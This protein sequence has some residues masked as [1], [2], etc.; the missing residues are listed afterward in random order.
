MN[1]ERGFSVPMEKRDVWAPATPE[2]PV[3]RPNQTPS[4]MQ[5]NQIGVENWQDLLGFYTDVLQDELPPGWQPNSRVDVN[6]GE[7][8]IENFAGVGVNQREQTIQNVAPVAVLNKGLHNV[9]GVASAETCNR[10]LPYSSGSAGVVEMSH[11][12]GGIQD[13]AP[14]DKFRSF[15]LNAGNAGSYLQN[16]DDV[17]PPLKVSSLAELLGMRSRLNAPTTNGD[18]IISAVEKHSSI[19]QHSQVERNWEDSIPQQNHILHANPDIGGYNLQ[20]MPSSRLS[21]AY[22]PSYN[23]NSPQRSEAGE[24][25]GVAGPLHLGTVTPDQQKEL[26]NNQ[27][28]QIP[29]LLID[30]ISTKEGHN[31]QN[32]MLPQ[33]AEIG[34][35]KHCDFVSDTLSTA[36]PGISTKEKHNFVDGNGEFD[37]NKTPPQKTPKRKKHRPKVVKEGKPRRTPKPAAKENKNPSGNPATKRKYVRKKGIKTSTNESV[38]AENGVEVPNSESQGKSCKRALNFDLENGI[39]KKT[40]CKEFDHQADNNQGGNASINLNVDFHNAGLKRNATCAVKDVHQNICREQKQTENAYNFILS[41][42]KI[43]S[44]ESLT[45]A[46]TV[47]PTASKDHTLNVIARNLNVRST[48]INQSGV[49]GKYGQVHHQT[50]GGL[51]QLVIL[52]NTS[53]QNLDGLRQSS[54]QSSPQLLEDLVNIREKQKPKRVYFHTEMTQPLMISQICSRGVSET[55]HFNKESTRPWLNAAVSSRSNTKNAETK[56]NG[57]GAGSTSADFTEQTVSPG[58]KRL[59]AQTYKLHMNG[60]LPCF[61]REEMSTLMNPAYETNK[62]THN[63][64]MNSTGSGLQFQ[65]QMAD[66]KYHPFAEAQTNSSFTTVAN[67]HLLSISNRDPKDIKRNEITDAPAHSSAKRQYTRRTPSN[68]T[69]STDKVLQYGHD[70]KN[71]SGSQE[72]KRNIFSVDDIT[73][74]MR[75]LQIS[76]NGNRTFEEV[77]NALVPYTGGGAVVPYEPSDP[78]KKRRPR[79]KVDLDPETNRLWNLLM[80]N[81][82]SESTETMDEDKQKRWEED[83]RVFRGRVDSFTARMHLV[84]GDRKFSKWKGSVVDSV[85]GVF[86]TQNVSDHL[87]S[88]AF[89]SLAAKFS[90]KSTNSRETSCQKAGN[91]SAEYVVL[92]RHP[93]GTTC[94]Q[95]MTREPVYDQNTVKSSKL[96]EYD[97]ENVP[98]GT[99]SVN[100]HI[101]RTEEGMVSSQMT[102]E[103]VYDHNTV[104]SSKLSEYDAENVPS[105]T[106][107]VN[108]H[109]RR[110]DE[111]MV[112]SQS[113]SESINFHPSEDIRS[114]SGSNSEVE[115]QVTGSNSRENCGPLYLF[116]E[117]EGITA[118]QK[119]QIPEIGFSF[120]DNRFSNNHHQYA[121]LGNRQYSGATSSTNACTYPLPSNVLHYQR[122]APASKSSW[123]GMGN[124]ES[125]VFA[126]LEKE[127]TSSLTSTLCDTTNGTYIEDLLDKA[128]Q[129]IESSTTEQQTGSSKFQPS[130]INPKV[131]TKHLEKKMNFPTE[132]ESR[133]SQHFINYK[134]G[135]MQE[136]F[137]QESS[138]LADP[139]KSAEVLRQNPTDN[140]KPS[141]NITLEPTEMKTTHA[142]DVQSSKISTTSTAQKQKAEKEKGKSFDWDSLRKQ[143]HLKGGTRERSRDTLDSLD[144]EALRNA[145]VREISDSIKERGMNNMLAARIKDFLNRLVKDHGSTDLEWLR[146]VQPDRVKDYLLSIRGLGLKSVECIRLLTLHHLAFPVDTN[147]GRIAVRLGWVPLQPLPEAL[148]LHL[149]EL[150]P[151]LESIQKYLWPRLCMLDQETLYE[152]HY[153]LIT[154]GK[155]FCTKRQPNCNACPMR[156]ECRHFASAFA[157]ARLALPGPEERRVVCSN[158]PT[159]PCESCVV[160]KPMPLPPP[161]D[162]L[163][164]GPGLT[165][166]C[167][168][169]IEEP[170]TPESSIEVTERDIEDVFY[171]DPDE[172]PEIKLNIEEFTTNLQSFIQENKEMQEGDMSKAIIALSPKFA[173]IPK[174]KLKHVSRLR[175][176]HQVYELPDSHPLLKGMDRR[177]PDDPSPYLL[178]LWTPGETADSVQPPEGKCSSSESGMCNKKTCFPCNSTREAQAQTARGTILIPCRTAM[179]GSFPLNGTYFQVNEV[180]ADDE[181]S[182]NPIHVP[183]SLIWN[184]PRRAVFFGTSVST[185]FKGMSTEGIQYCFWKGFVCVRGF[186]QKTRAPRPLKA[187]LH[188]P[189]SKIPKQ[190]E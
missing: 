25:S 146:D 30:E 60:E 54:F 182:M 66:I 190:N 90:A 47:P 101:R 178:A 113:S 166:N 48:N 81:E 78:I 80:G 112:S 69:S 42:D 76:N 55:G 159:S 86:L 149:L 85:I 3:L 31:K 120:Q 158:V 71:V 164:S 110:T 145:D 6:Q 53:Q 104:K 174:P 140:Q 144:Y 64:C 160:T 56:I 89:M 150:Y 7:P 99:F 18:R 188:L 74:R 189:A 180:F 19:S 88:S 39:G 26:Q 83:R 65:K 107:S 36:S 108:R 75:D 9:E 134:N 165:G 79:P 24:S 130:T 97:A 16:V 8:A 44:Q 62:V 17:V 2:K 168:P 169:I 162:N 109:I 167:E 52:A 37:L 133:D 177:E 73:D 51:S 154:F 94:H 63:W 153:Q 115:D 142:S 187:R 67:C 96:S 59:H 131:R 28:N 34:E 141:E 111:G 93:D 184:L 147:V 132:S 33:Q 38:D 152:L 43:P 40:K 49:Q 29:N 46:A 143:V 68:K 87:S 138:F 129:S 91:P 139:V 126:L 179:R 72:Y 84:Q 70:L 57:F 5:Q 121:N 12:N 125:D 175:T 41:V 163:G 14:V 20:Q 137:Q 103:P 118:F 116:K 4:G 98:S 23:R 1:L 77:R 32:F 21:V 22:R 106:C 170:T 13:V 15:D 155:V 181:T 176:E 157:S 156:G 171:E 151:V 161:E 135:G 114:S 27:I 136:T 61:G 11:W 102:R 45:P 128:G 117:A 100:R 172:I 50:T 127:C 10:L 119:N 124:R 148:Q 186:D 95:R 122:P 92:V 35:R 173:S 185:I 183:R 105:G 58:K 123:Q 82:G